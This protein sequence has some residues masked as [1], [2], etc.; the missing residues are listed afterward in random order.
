MK[1]KELKEMCS[2][3]KKKIEEIVNERKFLDYQ[4]EKQTEEIKSLKHSISHLEEMLNMETDIGTIREN[5]I[6]MQEGRID[7]LK[8][9][10][11]KMK[12]ENF[13][14]CLLIPEKF[15]IKE[16]MSECAD[17]AWYGKSKGRVSRRFKALNDDIE[18]LFEGVTYEYSYEA[19]TAGCCVYAIEDKKSNTLY[20]VDGENVEAYRYQEVVNGSIEDIQD[21][22]VSRELKFVEI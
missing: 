17:A 13:E 21:F 8:K 7:N 10:N 19:F 20:S 12:Q 5:I 22:I 14:M 3:L 4:L 6:K 11:S 2:T 16:I 18:L 1:K 9:E 15:P